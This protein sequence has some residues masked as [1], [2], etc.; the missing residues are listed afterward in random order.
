M[1]SR[2]SIPFDPCRYALP[3]NSGCV[4]IGFLLCRKAAISFSVQLNNM[5]V[6]ENQACAYEALQ[7]PA[8]EATPRTPYG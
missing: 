2:R 7:S 6:G 5:K 8:S 4:Y 1:A 3:E